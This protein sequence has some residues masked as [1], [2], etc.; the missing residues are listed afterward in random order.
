MTARITDEG[1]PVLADPQAATDKQRLHEATARAPQ[2]A[3]CRGWTWSR[4][5]P[6]GRSPST[7]TSWTSSGRT[8]CSPTTPCGAV[9]RRPRCADASGPLGR[10]R[11]ATLIHI[12]DPAPSRP[13]QDRCRLVQKPS[14]LRALKAR[15][16]EL[17]K[18]YVDKM[19]EQGPELDF[20]QRIGGQLPLYV[21]LSLLGLPESDFPACSSSPGELFGSEDSEVSARGRS[22][23]LVGHG[24]GFLQ[25]LRGPDGVATRAP[26]EDLAS[27]VANAKIS[28]NR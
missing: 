13:A 20:S 18:I 12:D 19:V 8:T 15:C 17:A 9:A 25:L 27:A 28:R 14:A 11:L 7:P 6:S 1:G 3:G 5:P 23:D 16:D 26:T 21:I 24:D 4:S 2:R 10:H 22:G